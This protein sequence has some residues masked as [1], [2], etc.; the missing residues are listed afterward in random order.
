V[1]VGVVLPVG[2]EAT[3]GFFVVSALLPGFDVRLTSGLDSCSFFFAMMIRFDD[4]Y[5]MKLK[6]CFIFQ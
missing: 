1:D 6:L 4:E 5:D 3:V 2:F